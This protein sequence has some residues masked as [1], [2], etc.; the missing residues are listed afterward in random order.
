MAKI[1]TVNMLLA[2]ANSQDWILAQVDVSNAF[3]N[4]DLYE[5]VYMNF[6]LAYHRNKELTSSSSN[7][8]C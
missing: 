2:I 1:V 3:L 6:S 5:E 7:L 4:G 8:V